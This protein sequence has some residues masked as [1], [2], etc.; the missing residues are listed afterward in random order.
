MKYLNQDYENENY[1]FQLFLLFI[2]EYLRYLS[3]QNKKKKN[4]S[5]KKRLTAY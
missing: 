2:M 3:Y 1:F 4:V 5:K